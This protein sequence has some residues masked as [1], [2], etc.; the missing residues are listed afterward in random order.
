VHYRY[1]WGRNPMGNLQIHRGSDIPL[2][3]QRS[4]DWTNGDLLKVLTGK[5]AENPALLN[6]GEKRQLSQALASE[7]RRRLVEEAKALLKQ[8]QEASAK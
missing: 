4:D 7:D 3:T 1:A 8:E 5:D 6:R 2:A